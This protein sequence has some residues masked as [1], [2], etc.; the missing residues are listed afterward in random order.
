MFLRTVSVLPF[1]C[2]TAE[3]L[4]KI[5][6]VSTQ[7]TVGEKEFS[8][9]AP[10]IVYALLPNEPHSDEHNVED[11]HDDDHEH[12]HDHNDDHN[13]GGDHNHDDDGDHD[14]DHDDEK[15]I[16]QNV[17]VYQEFLERY[18]TGKLPSFYLAVDLG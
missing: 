1:Q 8:K 3:S 12:D 17:N 18:E 9:F 10:I 6:N 7:S 4:F 13:H 2:I 16:T 5:S 14:E 15:Q 11:G